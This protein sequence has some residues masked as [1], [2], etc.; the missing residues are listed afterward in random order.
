A[1]TAPLFLVGA[2]SLDAVRPGEEVVLDGAEA[3]HAVQVR[4]IAVG[5]RLD[6]ADG[7]G[8][9]VEGSVARVEGH[10]STPSLVLTVERR[11][12]D[13]EPRLRLVLVQALAKGD[14]D[15]AAVESATELGI[16]LVVPWQAE[17]SVVI[18]RG[19]QAKKSQNRWAA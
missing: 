2:G 8:V 14:R 3:R 12:E 10:G 1:V 15:V 19:E 11:V 9:R 17:R 7:A 5:E 18:W 4:R 6:L 16:D 13:P